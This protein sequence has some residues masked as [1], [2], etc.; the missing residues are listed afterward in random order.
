LARADCRAFQSFYDATSGSRWYKCKESRSDPC[1]CSY[2]FP[3]PKLPNPNVGSVE[4]NGGHIT[5]LAV[6]S[7]GLQG[8]LPAELGQLSF[9][10]HLSFGSANEKG[11]WSN[12]LSGSLPSS[13]IQLTALSHFVGKDVGLVGTV[14]ALDFASMDKCILQ[15]VYS[16]SAPSNPNLFTC[17]LPRGARMYCNA[18]CHRGGSPNL[19]PPT[20]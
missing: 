13:L 17:P 10:T 3:I 19:K 8:T 7:N 14:P 9:L 2:S 20:D 16:S 12:D 11:S 15:K 5:K 4:C 18:T 6:F 1:S